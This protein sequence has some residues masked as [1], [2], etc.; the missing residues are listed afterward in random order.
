M[1][2]TAVVTGGA[3]GIGLGIVRHLLT[4]GWRVAVASRQATNW[5]SVSD[6]LD[7][8]RTTFL[9]TDIT[10]WE[11]NLQLFR[12]AHEWS[13]GQIDL[14]IANAGIADLESLTGPSDLDKDPEKP[15]T[16]PTDVNLVSAMWQL[17]L[18]IHY[19]RKTQRDKGM[20]GSSFNPKMIITGSL[21]SIYAFP[22]CV[23]YTASKHGLVG[24]VRSVGPLLLDSDN[25]A[26]NM[27]CP[28]F[29]PSSLSPKG[30]KEAWPQ[31]WITKVD[32][33]CRAVDEL[34]DERGRVEQDGRSDGKDG[35]IKAGEVVECA[36]H[37]LWYREP[38]TFPDESEK[39]L[40]EDACK[41]DGL[42]AQGIAGKLAHLAP[43]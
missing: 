34:S 1:A 26:L 2:K 31:H 23:Q 10:S 19:S 7:S 36:L 16:S 4:K 21:A 6:S 38:T 8:S 30:L 35:Q 40:I 43:S 28:S 33:V 32:I 37:N 27:T 5:E 41:K 3:T 42:W 17:K 25:I 29:I 11:S 39:F 18:F 13:G 24:L 22:P 9:T 20:A 14:F 15:D 12:E